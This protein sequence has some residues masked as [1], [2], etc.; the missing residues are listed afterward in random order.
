MPSSQ[1]AK[2]ARTCA[3]LRAKRAA[4]L[5]DLVEEEHPTVGL[6][7]QTRPIRERAG[8]L[9]FRMARRL[10]RVAARSR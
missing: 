7:E 3:E 10:L 1:G 5:A 6:L 9:P 8:E 4:Q 2:M